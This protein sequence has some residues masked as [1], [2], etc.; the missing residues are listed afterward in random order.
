M[1]SAEE[2]WAV[3]EEGTILH[4]TS[5]DKLV[6]VVGAGTADYDWN[7]KNRFDPGDPIRWF[8]QIEND[9]GQDAQI[10]LTYDVKGPNNDTIFYDQYVDVIPPGLWNWG[11]DGIVPAGLGGTHILTGSGLYMGT[12]SQ[13]IITY[14]VTGSTRYA[15][16]L[17]LAIK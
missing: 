13:S 7:W 1:L 14:T 3:G 5:L 9:T 11:D 2:G 16:Y 6:R 8:I 15:T 4:Y 17:P 10:E 12:M